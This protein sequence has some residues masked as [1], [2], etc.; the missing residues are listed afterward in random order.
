MSDPD[1]IENNPEDK[2]QESPEQAEVS[3]QLRDMAADLE[4][5]KPPQQ[6]GLL[7]GDYEFDH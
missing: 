7:R 6:E 5:G 4:G 1:I 3:R 2:A